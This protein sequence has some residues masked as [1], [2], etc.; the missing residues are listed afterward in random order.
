MTLL[1]EYEM[2]SKKIAAMAINKKHLALSEVFE[3]HTQISV[4]NL[5]TLKKVANIRQNDV[6]EI[7]GLCFTADGRSILRDLLEIHCGDR[8]TRLYWRS[9]SNVV[10]AVITAATTLDIDLQYNL[11]SAQKFKIF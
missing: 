8:S 4:I 6:K 11:C 9:M 5:S 2:R 1:P 7:S 3:N 10:A